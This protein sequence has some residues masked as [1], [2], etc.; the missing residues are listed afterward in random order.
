[1]PLPDQ[2]QQTFYTLGAAPALLI[3][4]NVTSVESVEGWLPRSD[5]ACHVLI[6][7]VME[8]W[9][10]GWLSLEV[11]PLSHGSSL[12][13]IQE[14]A[15][16]EIAGRYGEELATLAGGLPLQICPAAA[17]LAHEERRGRLN[18]A[19]L[20]LTR[21][22]GESFGAV[23][24][25][26]ERPAQLL[27]H[28]V[29]EP[30][31]ILGRRK[32]A[33]N[34]SREKLVRPQLAA[35]FHEVQV[36]ASIQPPLEL[37]FTSTGALVEM[38][39]QLRQVQSRRLVEVAGEPA[40]HPAR[41][42]LAATLMVYPLSRAAWVNAG[43][44]ISIEDGET[45][46]RALY[47]I[48]RFDDARPWFHRAVEAK[49]KGDVHGRVDKQSLALSLREGSRCLRQVGQNG[50]AEA[51]EQEASRLEQQSPGC[52]SHRPG[53]MITDMEPLHV[54]EAEAAKDLKGIL[55]R[56]QGGTEVIIERDA[57]PLAV[58]RAA[59]PAR[60]KLSE[61]IAML[62][63]DSTAT[64]DPDF[65]NDVQAAIDSHRESLEPPSWD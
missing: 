58:I 64:I 30:G 28:A 12:A 21:E 3:Y 6:T 5:M 62:P 9:D 37:G 27:L 34:E 16:R 22:A 29:L 7:T 54:T 8:R 52:G 41:A 2:G 47:E 38:T 18:S 11:R 59:A 20:V 53:A 14:L 50:Q 25:R 51:W 61:C 55:E 23:Y 26:L 65:A 19:R 57:Q 31:G 46:G 15:G 24:E 1:M 39:A 56:V 60:R 13:L 35:A 40:A 42:D 45:I 44:G 48:G 10:R 36:L 17:T 32:H 63:E 43:K 33:Q 4:D 49:Q